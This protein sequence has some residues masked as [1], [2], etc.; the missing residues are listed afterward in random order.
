MTAIALFQ[1]PLLSRAKEFLV[2]GL[3]QAPNL[4]E[5]LA[6]LLPSKYSS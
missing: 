2:Y 3:V 4:V 6:C 5:L 1:L